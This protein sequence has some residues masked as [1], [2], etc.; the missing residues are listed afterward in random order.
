MI[1]FKA[2]SGLIVKTRQKIRK[3]LVVLWL[4]GSAGRKQMTGILNYV[5]NGHP[6]S[7]NLITD[8]AEF[9]EA[10]IKKAED[11]GID[12]II[13]HIGPAAA[14]ALAKSRIPTVLIDF[15]PPS[16]ITRKEAIAILL[17]PDEEI[18]RCGADYFLKL[19]NFASFG[20][21]PDA[22][23][24]GWSR[25]RER[26]FKQ[27][28]EEK[29]I[30]CLVYN[31]SV[32]SIGDWLTT[33]PKPA[34][35]MVAYDIKA[36]EALEECR[37]A[38]LDVPHQVSLLGVD[39]DEIVCDYS[40][41]SLSSVKIDHEAF[42]REAAKILTTLM[43][44]RRKTGLKRIYMP[45]GSV[46]ERES[47]APT[48]PATHIV[49]RIREYI[50]THAAEKIS[51]DDIVRHLGGISRRMVDRRFHE[52][53]GSSI[54]RAIEDTRLEM[55]KRRL[56]TSDLNINKISRLCGY[57]NVQRLKYVF[58]SRVGMSMREYRA[59]KGQ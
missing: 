7:I 39:N 4:A 57:P 36:K 6:W 8:P 15:P 13:G 16:L 47:T 25:L 30:P 17:D 22:A 2:T 32:G 21:I 52:A 37:K 11:D 48:P 56:L 12:G 24:R 10:A 1:H 42:G 19:G 54:R 53:T 18:G 3:V 26:G 51:V 5:K 23:N 27:A 45:V 33:L 20:F 34:A 35:I 59:S 38:H 29:N 50:A 40:T 31:P 43:S 14:D 41:P 49:R 44:A 28:L 58:K 46:I 55:V 9:D